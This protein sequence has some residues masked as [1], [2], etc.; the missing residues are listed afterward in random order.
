MATWPQTFGGRRVGPT[1]AEVQQMAA[2]MLSVPPVSCHQP[3]PAAHHTGVCHDSGWNSKGGSSKS[4][5]VAAA[6][7]RAAGIGIQTRRAS[8]RVFRHTRLRVVLVGGQAFIRRSPDSF[9]VDNNPFIRFHPEW[10]CTPLAFRSRRIG[11]Q[12]RC[13]NTSTLRKRVS[14]QAH[15]LAR[16]ACR[17]TS[18]HPRSGGHLTGA[19]MGT[20]RGDRRSRQR[21]AQYEASTFR[22]AHP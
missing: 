20:N 22:V 21:W 17:G 8:Q 12:A 6:L 14:F 2:A 9:R 1:Q 16:R 19:A 18:I 15:S 5:E 4:V 13:E 3:I 7:G 11:R 10:R